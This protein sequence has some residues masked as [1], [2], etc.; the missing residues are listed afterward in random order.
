[1]DNKNLFKWKDTKLYLIIIGCLI[2]I[3]AYYQPLLALIWAIALAYLIYHY[4]KTI[5]DKEREWTKYIE[6]LAEEFDSVTKHAVFNMP[7]PLVILEADG[8]IS[9]YNTR[10]STMIDEEDILN[11]KK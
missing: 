3:I 9:W 5:H 7:F 6:S 1:M 8:T 4:N 2:I 11:E 10:F